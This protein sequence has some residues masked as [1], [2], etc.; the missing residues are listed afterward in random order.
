MFAAIDLEVLVWGLLAVVWI[1][2]QIA[3]QFSSNKEGKGREQSRQNMPDELRE[4]LE[5]VEKRTGQ[6]TR[7]T[8]EPVPATPPPAPTRTSPV[9]QHT[10]RQAERSEPSSRPKRSGP[11]QRNQGRISRSIKSV[12]RARGKVNR[13]SD[14]IT[15][16]LEERKRKVN[17]QSAKQ[18]EHLQNVVGQRFDMGFNKQDVSQSEGQIQKV[19]LQDKGD[20]QG[21]LT[22][23]IQGFRMP[24]IP[25]PAASDLSER[26]V[27]NRVHFDK[28]GDAR[29]ALLQ[30][31]VISS[32]IALQPPGSRELVES[33]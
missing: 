6:E 17:R 32:P 26:E 22:L 21:Y 29:R 9:S 31:I 4:F 11:A 5:N 12:N 23:G 30:S 33:K 18:A 14:R 28:P 1:I 27:E 7:R 15:G 19:G 2:A 20:D 25:L 8:P 16:A 10:A 24:T 3:S 13:Q